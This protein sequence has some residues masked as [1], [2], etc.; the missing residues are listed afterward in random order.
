MQHPDRAFDRAQLLDR[1]WGRSVYV[2]ERTVDVHVLRLRRALK[3]FGLD[4]LVETVRGVGYRLAPAAAIRWRDHRPASGNPDSAPWRSA[5]SILGVGWAT[6]AWGIADLIG[7]LV[8]VGAARA[9]DVAVAAVVTPSVRRPDSTVEFWQE[10]AVR[11]FRAL[12]QSRARMRRLLTRL[13]YVRSATEALP[14]GAILIKHNGEIE[15]FNAAAQT[16]LGLAAARCRS[17]FRIA[18]AQSGDRRARQWS[19]GGGIRGNHRQSFRPATRSPPDRHRRN[20]V[21]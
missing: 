8:W 15:M 10:P 11:V 20:R 14:D 3:P 4:A 19:G 9:R 7:L 16:L 2:E 5:S 21:C 6:R 13:R 17:E 1:V 18:G 12:R